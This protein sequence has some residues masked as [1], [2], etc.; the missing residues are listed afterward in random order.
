MKQT[1]KR[2]GSLVL[3]L[4]MVVS[5]L[6]GAVFAGGG[7]E[8]T[9]ENLAYKVLTEDKEAKTGTVVLVGY[10]GSEPTG[11]LTVAEAVYNNGINYSITEIGED[12]F[13]WCNELT[14]VVIGDNVENIGK[15]AFKYS[16]NIVNITLG[17]AVKTI[18][19][20]AF[21]GTNITEINL[22]ASAEVIGEDAFNNCGELKEFTVD[23][24]NLNF[25]DENGVL[26]SKDKKTL[27]LYPAGKVGKTYTIPD[28]VKTIGEGAFAANKNLTQIDTTN[29]VTISKSAFNS[30]ALVGID[31]GDFVKTIGENAFYS[32]MDLTEVNFSANSSLETIEDGVFSY[33]NSLEEISLP[34]SLKTLGRWVFG[35]YELESISIGKNVES[36]RTNAI[37]NVPVL[38]NLT[39]DSDNANYMTEDNILYNKGKTTLIRYAPGKSETTF[40]ISN[41]VTKIEECAFYGT[42]NLIDVTVPDSIET[43]GDE[44]FLHSNFTSITFLGDTPPIVGNKIFSY[45]NNLMNI[46]VP[47]GSVDEYKSA[48]G[49]YAEKVKAQATI[50]Q[51][52][53]EALIA[54]PNTEIKD[55]DIIILGE[56]VTGN[57]SRTTDLSN[58]TIE[59]N[60][61]TINGRLWFG[62]E[63]N[64]TLKD[65]T[66]QGPDDSEAIRLSTGGKLKT[67]GKVEINGGNGIGYLGMSGVFSGIDLTITASD[68]TK[69]TAGDASED[70]NLSGSAVWVQ[71]GNLTLDGGS[72]IFQGGKGYSSYGALVGRDDNLKD[73]IISSGSPKLIGGSFN[74]SGSNGAFVYGG[75]HISS[76]GSPEFIGADGK[77]NSYRANGAWA[78]KLE[79]TAGS[80]KFKGGSVSKEKSYA[81]HGISLYDSA[82]ISGNASPSF[83]GGNGVSLEYGG[84]GLNFTECLT[85][86]TSGDVEFIGGSNCQHGIGQN[87]SISG[88]QTGINLKNLKGKIIADSTKGEY[89]AI[90]LYVGCTITYPDGLAEAKKYNGT[91]KMYVLDMGD[92][93]TVYTATLNINLDDS[94]FTSQV[95]GYTLK[96][97]GDESMAFAMNGSGATRTAEVP[98]GTWKVYENFDDIY[99]GVNI[100]INDAPTSGTL[101]YYTVKYSA[102]KEG[103]T[104]E[105]RIELSV[106]TLDGVELDNISYL[107]KGDKASFAATG[108]GAES[109]TYRWSG[110]HGTDTISS[111]GSIYTINPVQG[112]IDITCTITGSGTSSIPIPGNSGIIT[113]TDITENSLT[114]NW[115]NAT[116]TVEGGLKYVVFQ[117]KGAN[118]STVSECTSHPELLLN[119]EPS[120]IN[121]YAV[122]GLSPNT[123]Y[124]FNVIVTDDKMGM[125]AYTMVSATTTS[126]GNE[127]NGGGGNGSGSGGP[128]GGSTTTPITITPGNKPNQPITTSAPVTATAGT[129]GTANAAIT[130]KII[131]DT[132]AKAQADA[133]SQGKTV[134]GTSVALNVTM[135]QGATALT[136]TLTPN[137]LN[138]LVSAG[139]ISLEINGAP[140]SLG[141]D[142]TALK[143]I[144]KQSGGNITISIAPA[145]E[146]SKEAKALMGNRPVYNITIS[147]VK[148]GK[149]TNVN[150]LG[151][152]TATLLIHY[153]PGKNEAVGYLFGVYVDAKGKATQIDGSTYD[154]NVGAILLSTNHFSV[155]GVGYTAPSAKFTDISTHWNKEAIDYVVGRGLLSGTSETTFAPNTA[156]TRGMLVTALGRLAG[157]DTKLYTTNSFTDVKADSDFRPYIEWAYQKGIVHGIGKQQFAPDRAITREE[158]AVIFANYAK[159]TGYKLPVIREA[160]TYSDASSIGSAY[161]TAVMA[162]QQAG[163]MMGGTDN[164]FNPKASAT[165]AEVS[166]MLHRYIKLT[167]DPITAQGWALND[168]GQWLYYKEGKALTS[169]QTIDG[170]KYLFNTNGTLKTGWVKEVDNWRY[171]SGNKILT[172]WWDI[173][174]DATKKTY[175]FETNG[176]MISGKWLQ[177][178]DKWYYLGV[179]GS[180]A[181][182]TT[183]DGHEVDDNGVRKNK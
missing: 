180:L 34:D 124:Y 137:S 93:S 152:G 75:I 38:K 28:S 11:T 65:I 49:D 55:G 9:I 79:I 133:K 89:S 50:D 142:L 7:D 40:E 84:D 110:T 70:F 158:I 123:T 121:T 103:T 68:G 62:K 33:C 81:G 53:W 148:D 46:Y 4:C 8:F 21:Q 151:N 114:L 37:Y 140:V 91:G 177:I 160:T 92:M 18:G 94:P 86:S 159:S 42:G 99:T 67:I 20:E 169:T 30:S 136:V 143:E 116:R 175:Y 29:V 127:G 106:T 129:G 176:N 163:I 119:G 63:I 154:T 43:I 36:I 41:T 54:N 52:G 10:A 85:I 167:I 27:I 134:N 126:D 104:S 45:C 3:A 25:S 78:H 71:S 131:T 115:A 155:Y 144:Q 172:G 145:T 112:K 61:H 111:T 72:P 166:S 16:D 113:V 90:G 183:I 96:L 1:W 24:S 156:M 19:E 48:L 60:G 125:A 161:K 58:L 74:D 181:K 14:A 15:G 107:I 132:I 76:A 130:D 35:C 173:G 26:L 138:S 95:G 109:Y 64:L 82:T 153:T 149:T 101:D 139:V 23:K 147:T 56:D 168:V 141:L 171:Y 178:D 105:G 31:I 59:G 83:T 87:A 117:S 47:S 57:L 22:P 174:S 6:P 164:K 165:R 44:A 80:P 77:E 146:L 88:T 5:M 69:I 12:A 182:N 66:V 17:N 179:D 98:K 120:D 135:P 170:M 108:M 100:T 157:V 118:I 128:S 32:C 13:N 150:S 73:L 162:M 2:I 39:V 102:T 97:E 51:T 122:S